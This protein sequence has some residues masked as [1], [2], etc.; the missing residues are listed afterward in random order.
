MAY[1]RPRVAKD[2][3][4]FLHRYQEGALVM[5]ALLD[6]AGKGGWRGRQD[7]NISLS[8]FP[9]IKGQDPVEIWCLVERLRVLMREALNKRWFSDIFIKHLDRYFANSYEELDERLNYAGFQT[10]H[11]RCVM[12]LNTGGTCSRLRSF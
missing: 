1:M 10:S 5:L 11:I 12:I 3:K 7:S 9:G 2:L 8:M 4:E 6:C